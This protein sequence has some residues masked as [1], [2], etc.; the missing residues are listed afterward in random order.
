MPLY[1]W[2]ALLF[3]IV[4]HKLTGCADLSSFQLNQADSSASK[5]A[6]IQEVEA[7]LTHCQATCN[8]IAQV[9]MNKGLGN[10]EKSTCKVFHNVLQSLISSFCNLLY[11]ITHIFLI[12]LQCYPNP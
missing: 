10:F 12:G 9:C 6:R 2:N 11:N 1:R 8:R 5:E 3:S 7:K 4:S